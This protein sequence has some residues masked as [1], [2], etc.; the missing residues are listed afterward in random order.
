[1]GGGSAQVTFA[2][3]DPIGVSQLADHLY[4]VSTPIT[5]ID[6]FTNSYLNLGLFAA[7]HT[8]YT[9]GHT[10]DNKTYSSE[11]VNPIIESEPFEYGAKI[12]FMNGKNYSNSIENPVVDFDTCAGLIKK[13]ILHLV[14]PKPITLNQHQ[15]VATNKFWKVALLTGLVGMFHFVSSLLEIDSIRSFRFPR[16]W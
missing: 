9:S 3:N 14:N 7:R 4:T 1:M 16:R 6:V 12:H 15:I 8:V 2:I 11:C 13:K 5:E 10:N